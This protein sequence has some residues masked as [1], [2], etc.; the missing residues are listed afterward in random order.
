MANQSESDGF[1]YCWSDHATGKVYIGIHLGDP[2]DGY[3]CSSKAMKQEYKERPCDF[4]REILFCGP[5]SICSKLEK[6]LLTALFKTDKNTFYNRSNGRK[7]L[8]DDVIKN[9][10]RE[11]AQGRKMPEGHLEK[12]L[13]ARIGKPGPRKGVTLSEETRKKISDS[14]RGVVTP[15]MGHKHTLETKERMSESAKKRPAIT[16]ETRLKLSELAKADWAKRK[17][18]KSLV[19]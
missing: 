5:Y 15:K 11:K 8:F 9:K 6:E 12:M 13:A 7:I 2:S 18:E 1:T 3:I 10:I 4:T 14:K 19:Y 17:L 16:Y